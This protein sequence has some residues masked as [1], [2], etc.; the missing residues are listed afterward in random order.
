MSFRNLFSLEGRVAVVTGASSGI[1]QSIAVALAGAGAKV[2]IVARRVD[3]LAITSQTIVSKGGTAAMIRGDLSEVA[4][5]VQVAETCAHFFGSPDILINAAGINI[6]KPMLDVSQEDWD[7]VLGLNLRAPFF[8]AQ[9]LV[10]A[11]LAKRWGRIVNVA[12]L[13]SVRAFANSGPYGASKGGVLQLTRAQ[14][15]AWSA[16]GVTANAIAPGFFRTELTES[17]A[18]DA[19]QW[20]ANAAHTFVGRNGEL[21]D[22]DGTAI[23]LSSRASNYVTGQTIFVDGGYSAG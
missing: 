12:S 17:V 3:L 14:A 19:P 22:L 13:Q 8:L 11:M 15:Q 9:K 23:Y 2:V 18:N 10:P 7:R 21:T 5:C 1:G 4:E 16:H 6:R 20:A